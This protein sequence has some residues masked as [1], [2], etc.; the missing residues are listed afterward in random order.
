[1]SP[2]PTPDHQQRSH[3]EGFL[4]SLNAALEGYELERYRDLEEEHPTVHVLGLPRSG[5]T[6][7]LQLLV[8]NTDLAYIDHV[9]AA[10]WAAPVTGLRLSEALRSH[11]SRPSS[12]DSDYGRTGELSEPH[13]FSYFWARLLG[14]PFGLESLA[15]PVDREAV[16]WE[17][18]RRVMTNMCDAAQRPVV[19]KS[20]WAIWHLERL[21]QALPRTVVVVVRRDP[22]AVGQSLVTMRERLYG[23]REAW[24][25]IKP[26][27]YSWLKD[28]DCAT[29]IA[30]QIHL[31]NRAIDQGLRHVA[32]AGRVDVAYE[33]VCRD[34]NAFVDR[35]ATAVAEQGGALR[36]TGSAQPF[37][38]SAGTQDPA[39]ARALQD[40]LANF[41]DT[42]AAYDVETLPSRH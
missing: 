13:E 9:A 41:D 23:T 20:F 3:D 28:T 33:E 31:V 8:A 7:A 19:F 27:E 18:F 32:P 39:T 40:A 16:D 37:E 34:P 11:T 21:C 26:R 38:P 36:V 25:S 5:T 22:L 6:L 15:E 42:R 35:V 2:V 10:F 4:E 14:T 24:A 29:Q 12:F 30:G 1:M 17:F